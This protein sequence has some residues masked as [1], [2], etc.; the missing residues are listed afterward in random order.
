MITKQKNKKRTTD[1]MSG[2]IEKNI[3]S[4]LFK[5]IEKPQNIFSLKIINVYNDKY[6]INIWGKVEEGGFEKN[7]IVKSHFVSYKN[8]K[9]EIIS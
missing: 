5:Q 8:K 9:L 3:E 2:N 7:K 1:N 6:R 4:L